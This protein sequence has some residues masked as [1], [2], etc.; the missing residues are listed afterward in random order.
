MVWRVSEVKRCF[1]HLQ[2]QSDKAV[3][4]S[5][6]KIRQLETELADAKNKLGSAHSLKDEQ[7]QLVH[8]L[9]QDINTLKKN[10]AQLEKE[11]DDV[12]VRCTVW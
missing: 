9:K 12:L 6:L 1:R 7:G 8:N 4:E 11:K 10:L 2:E 3:A 5:Q